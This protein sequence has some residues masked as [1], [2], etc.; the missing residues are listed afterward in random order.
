M[1]G[2]YTQNLLLFK[3]VHAIPEMFQLVDGREVLKFRRE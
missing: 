1:S 3:E 2:E